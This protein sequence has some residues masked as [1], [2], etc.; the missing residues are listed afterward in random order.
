MQ[1]TTSK[2]VLSRAIILPLPVADGPDPNFAQALLSHLGGHVGRTSYTPLPAER[3]AS[4]LGLHT[5]P[6]T[7]LAVPLDPALTMVFHTD[8]FLT[9]LFL[10]GIIPVPHRRC[11][12]LGKNT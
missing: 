1:N 4:V 11:N 5:R 7:A 8:V 10:R 3:L 6:K 2:P 12:S 9:K